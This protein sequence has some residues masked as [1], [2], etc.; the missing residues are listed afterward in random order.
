MDESELMASLNPA[1]T[2]EDLK[3]G[4]EIDKIL[5]SKLTKKEF[6]KFNKFF[7]K[8]MRKFYLIGQGI[9]EIEKDS[10]ITASTDSDSREKKQ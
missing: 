9:N 4:M 5:K 6:E 10:E 7:A 8:T 2:L 3:E 1:R